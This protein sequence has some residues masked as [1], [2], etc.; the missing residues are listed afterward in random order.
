M[1]FVSFLFLI[2]MAV[3]MGASDG[4]RGL[5]VRRMSVE[6]AMTAIYLFFAVPTGLIVIL[7]YGFPSLQTGIWNSL[8]ISTSLHLP[9]TLLLYHGIKKTDLTVMGGIIALAPVSILFGEWIINNDAP[10][11]LGLAGV[12][13]ATIGAYTLKAGK[14]QKGWLQ[15]VKDLFIDPGARL[16]LI[17]ILVFAVAVPYQRRAIKLSNPAFVLLFEVSCVAII[18]VIMTLA[19]KRLWTKEL[20]ENAW[21]IIKTGSIWSIGMVCVYLALQDTLGSYVHTM[22][23][24]SVF[25]LLFVANKSLKEDWKKPLPGLITIATGAIMIALS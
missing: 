5:L 9:V 15:P 21:L 16:G 3:C 6:T 12:L 11:R 25:P 10:S 7:F 1:S 22:R 24:L 17:M 14:F 8:L 18:V 13:V 4:G 2:L 23:A 20:K 19:K